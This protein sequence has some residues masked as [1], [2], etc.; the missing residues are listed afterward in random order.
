[1]CCF[2]GPVEL[3]SNTNIF[4]RVEG[5][6]Q[7]LVYEMEFSAAEDLAMVLPI[8]VAAGCAEDAVR[9][10][11][12]EDYPH[13]F[14]DLNLLF[15]A[16]AVEGDFG[17]DLALPVAAAAPPLEVHSVGAFDASFVPTIAD[18]SR[19]DDRFRLPEQVWDDLPGYEEFGFAVFKL[20]GGRDQRVHPMAFSFPTRDSRSLFFPTVHIHDGTVRSRATFDHALYCQTQRPLPDWEESM[21]ARERVDT[22][23]AQGIVIGYRRCYRLMLSGEMENRDT[24]AHPFEDA[25]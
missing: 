17:D 16:L 22:E 18:F 2:T 23:K 21:P 6:E 20:K 15:P 10:L 13:F 4:A 3:V 12:F 24:Y 25:A 8:P 11:S 19:L 9:F 14:S 7:F 1:M 5:G